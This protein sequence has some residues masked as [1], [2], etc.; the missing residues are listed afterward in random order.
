MRGPEAPSFGRWRVHREPLRERLARGSAISS[1]EP[2][3]PASQPG[4]DR[5]QAR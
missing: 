1:T 4:K 3:H 5:G 2:Y